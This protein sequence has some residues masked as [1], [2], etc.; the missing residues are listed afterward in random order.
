MAT[1]LTNP[2]TDRAALSPSGEVFEISKAVT[3]EAAHFMGG[4]PEGH[5]YRNLHGHSFRLEA[6]VRGTVK[7]GEEWVEDF[8][9][10]TAELNRVAGLLDHMLLNDIEGLSVP[11]LERI[12]LWVANEL[13]TALPGLSKVTLARPSLNE[14]C[15]LELRG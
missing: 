2:Q 8:S 10:L 15:S 5:P 14:S 3:F 9:H 13:K 4:K 11:T 6:S 7:P 12:C 1:E